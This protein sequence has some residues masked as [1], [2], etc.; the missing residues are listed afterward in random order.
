MRLGRRYFSFAILACATMH[1][2]AAPTIHASFAWRPQQ[3]SHP[4][5]PVPGSG[6]P[7]GADKSTPA[8][9]ESAPATQPADKQAAKPGAT[10]PSKQ[11]ATGAPAEKR[12]PTV[13]KTATAP[14]VRPLFFEGDFSSLFPNGKL[15]DEDRKKLF[16][17]LL[18]DSGQYHPTTIINLGPNFALVSNSAPTGEAPATL[19]VAGPTP[20]VDPVRVKLVSNSV[21]Q[22]VQLAGDFRAF[23]DS[24]IASPGA[25]DPARAV[26]LAA[27]GQ[28]TIG[29]V[30]KLQFSATEVMV[31][32]TAPLT[33]PPSYIRF[34]KPGVPTPTITFDPVKP[35]A[36]K[37]VEMREI[38]VGDFCQQNVQGDCTSDLLRPDAA[39]DL[40]QTDEPRF[41]VNPDVM[42]PG[43]ATLQGP[44]SEYRPVHLKSLG[45]DRA[46][47]TFSAPPGFKPAKLF[48]QTNQSYS[49]LYTP[50]PEEQTANLNYQSDELSSVCN[51]KAPPMPPSDTYAVDP[52]KT[53]PDCANTPNWVFS[54]KALSGHHNPQFVA[55]RDNILVVRLT[56]ASGEEPPAIIIENLFTKVSVFARRATKPG[57]N[58][59][60][61]N[62]DMSIMDQ[63]TAQRNYGNRIAKR[64]L[65]VTLDI[66]NPTDTKVQFNKSALYFDVDY[67][68]SRER[69]NGV[70]D[71]FQAVGELSTLG[72]YQ[73][74]VY[75]PPFIAGRA[76]NKP[77]REARF[78]LEQNVRQAPENFLSMLGSFDYTTS[79]TDEK[80]KA[81]ELVGSI[82]TNIATGG[83]I[84]DA[85][86]AF[87]AGTSI[88][89]GTFLP[90][91]RSIALNT[92]YINRLRSN[93][94]AQTLQDTI[95]IPAKGSA[96][97]IVL[98]PRAGI[99]A[100][101]DIQVPVMIKR[102]LDV[103]LVEEVVTP[104]A[105]TAS[106]K[107]ACTVGNS[108]AQTR[109]ALGEES[110]EAA[111]ADGGSTFS[112]AKGPLASVTF[113]KNGVVTKCGA[114]RDA[115]AQMDLAK[116][117]VEAK[118]TLTDLGLAATTIE[119]VDDS[120]VLVDILG[121]DKTYHFDAKGNIAAPYTFLFKAISTEGANAGETQQKIED[122][123]ENKALNAAATAAIKSS[124][125]DKGKPTVAK[126]G[127]S[128][129][130]P[131]PD[132]KNGKVTVSF[133]NNAAKPPV[134]VVD[135][136]T[137]QGDQPKKI[138]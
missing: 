48:L 76:D 54:L 64:Y 105:Q 12:A 107:G 4:A 136:I 73:P 71:F 53:V 116:T 102:V 34:E 75:K 26:L 78:G 104:V 66:K 110:S 121:V 81:L 9:K 89:S 138:D 18:T 101:T 87:K 19:I 43:H 13:K 10:D 112:Y 124:N 70:T 50:A 74:S 63:T 47:I 38:V 23:A 98:L 16:A 58:T 130:Y 55:L 52:D 90:G 84:A 109:V 37:E 45:P 1:A 80:L 62:V 77:P 88:F 97:T 127:D 69:P 51:Q 134:V 113:D 61:L 135:K 14:T 31:D 108:K 44:N 28:T 32:Y 24:G 7:A 93:L 100:F 25:A 85:S 114:A 21:Y 46:D 103:H 36:Q 83:V 99:L 128:L 17:V 8:N 111:N 119:L 40:S 120:T 65:A 82:L 56:F 35:S 106:K 123:L 49:F 42:Q 72:L 131:S 11:P 39:V 94:V 95:Q 3:A 137:F 30:T 57:G 27:D 29:K 86:G 126:A 22:Q 96:T 129:K 92:S 122:F 41:T 20:H 118:Q 5:E 59:N 133:K 2:T 91:V 68:E 117:L 115:T 132:V 79:Q 60:L 125:V 15:T 67:I 33:P 6:N